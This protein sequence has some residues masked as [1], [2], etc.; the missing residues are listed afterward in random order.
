MPSN[1]PPKQTGNLDV[2]SIISREIEEKDPDTYR[3]VSWEQA[4]LDSAERQESLEGIKQNREERKLYAKHYYGLV[5][6]WV[7]AIIVLVL[8]H[9]V[10]A[11]LKL[12]F[13]SDAVLMTLLGTTTATVISIIYIV[14]NYLFP[15]K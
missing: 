11:A 6:G 5:R 13:L 10:L 4:A 14:A 7:I 8:V 2:E 3:V 9:G 12:D 15:K 1:D